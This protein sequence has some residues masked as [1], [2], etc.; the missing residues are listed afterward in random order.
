[1]NYIRYL[2]KK[3]LFFYLFGVEG[4]KNFIITGDKKTVQKILS[5]IE[6]VTQA[7]D[8]ITLVNI[9]FSSKTCKN[10]SNKKIENLSDT[11]RDF[12]YFVK[13]FGDFLKVKGFLNI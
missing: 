4:L 9:K 3:R 10:L 1:M 2:A 13:S 8:K 5:D 7:D 12:F 6:K 11:A